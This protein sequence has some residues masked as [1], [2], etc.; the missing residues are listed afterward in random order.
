MM[1]LSILKKNGFKNIT[2]VLG[3]ISKIKD[4]GAS[5]VEPVNSN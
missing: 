5:L 4:A 2:N 3:G 1:A